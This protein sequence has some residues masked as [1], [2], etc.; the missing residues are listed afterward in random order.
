MIA[1][2][3]PDSFLCCELDENGNHVLTMDTSQV[4]ECNFPPPRIVLTEEQRRAVVRALFRPGDLEFFEK[5]D[6][7]IRGRLQE[8]L[9]MGDPP[10]T[11]PRG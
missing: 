5:E 11:T 8:L 3:Y 9:A 4:V 1:G 6:K 2:F 10:I 7:A